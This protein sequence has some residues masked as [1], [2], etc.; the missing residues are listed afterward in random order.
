[1]SNVDKK[2]NCQNNW[3]ARS[4][5]RNLIDY[6]TVVLIYCILIYFLYFEIFF[7]YFIGVFDNLYIKRTSKI[8]IA[9]LKHRK[10]HWKKSW[11]NWKL[12]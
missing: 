4:D 6:Q 8:K 5:R 10:L 3:N 7:G 11:V 9:K 1:M 2:K 12:N